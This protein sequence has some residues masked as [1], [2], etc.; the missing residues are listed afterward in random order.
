M[1]DLEEQI[2][3]GIRQG[4][5]HKLLERGKCLELGSETIPSE[6]N[7]TVQ[8]NE[9]LQAIRELVNGYRR[10][11]FGPWIEEISWKDGQP[12]LIKEVFQR[13]DGLEQTNELYD[14]VYKI[15]TMGI[16]RLQI[17]QSDVLV[18]IAVAISTLISWP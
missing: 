10:N 13:L 9:V 7:V 1:S 2:R 14:P 15:V 18:A 8:K 17:T 11:T 3:Q 4:L 12:G 5:L 6:D 16:A